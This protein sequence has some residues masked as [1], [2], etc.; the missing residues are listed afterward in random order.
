MRHNLLQSSSQD[1]IHSGLLHIEQD[2]PLHQKS[3]TLRHKA[4]AT[5]FQQGESMEVTMSWL[6]GRKLSVPQ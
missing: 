6:E 4:Q 1:Q 3:Q 2:K 5:A